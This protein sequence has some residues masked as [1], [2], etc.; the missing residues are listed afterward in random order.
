MSVL[1]WIAAIVVIGGLAV[2]LIRNERRQK[3][4][5]SW[6]SAE[7]TIE[8]SGMEA[9][10]SGRPA[11]DLPCFAFSYVVNGEYYSGRFSL[12]GG[13]DRSESLLREMVDRKINVKYDPTRPESYMIAEDV[14]EGCEVGRVPD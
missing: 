3:E 5:Q 12:S 11:A 4:A 1:G 9:V 2:Q 8:S 13:K 10:G 14:I 6:P 7:A